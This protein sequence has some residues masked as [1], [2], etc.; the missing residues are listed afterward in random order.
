[1]KKV[2]SIEATLASQVPRAN[3]VWVSQAKVANLL[4]VL[5][6]SEEPE[7]EILEVE[8]V[9]HASSKDLRVS[10]RQGLWQS[11][12]QHDGKELQSLSNDEWMPYSFRHQRGR[13]RRNNEVG[14]LI[15]TE[16]K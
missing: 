11:K 10:E 8:N 6:D 15:N 14:D 2:R 5:G 9:L 4:P 3:E 16:A 7:S 12:R 1:M 13:N